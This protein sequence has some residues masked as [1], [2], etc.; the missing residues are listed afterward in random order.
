MHGPMNVKLGFFYFILLWFSMAR[1]PA[2]G[3]GLLVTRLH[4]YTQSHHITLD[5]TTPDE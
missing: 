5:R 4:D 1:Q 2:V 3:L